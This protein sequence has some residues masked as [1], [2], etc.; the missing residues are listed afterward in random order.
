MEWEER[1]MEGPR[2][3]QS[4]EFNEILDF[5][6]Y[7]LRPKA[8]WSISQEYPTALNSENM[9]N[10]RIIKAEGKIAAHAVVQYSITKT[11][12][13]LFKVGAIGSVVTDP[14]FRNQGLSKQVINECAE[15]ARQNGCD[16]AVLWTNLYDLYR[17]LGFEL[18]GTELAL[19]IEKNFEPPQNNLRFMDTLRVAPEAL[20]RLYAE[21]TMGAIRVAD[22]F[23]RYLNIPNTHLYTAWDENN[24]LKAYAVEG[25]GADLIG[26]IHEWGGGVSSLLPLLAHI[27]KVKSSSIT[28]ICSQTAENLCRQL[29]AYGALCNRGF[30]G[31]FRILNTKN[32][33]FKLRRYARQLG[34][35]DWIFEFK[36]GAFYLGTSNKLFR[37][38]S[39]QDI[40]K[41][42]FGPLKASELE[43]FDKSTA[44]MIEEVLPLPFWIW[45]WDSV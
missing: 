15:A 40:I 10:I 38:E 33:S 35:D 7:N 12:A 8:T 43:G 9:N 36:E 37:T 1:I 13:G 28:L 20:L 26:Y 22:D 16:F 3:P 39:E 25:K 23:R 4:T 14:E 32:M 6:N 30:L 17:K 24:T 5:L 29:Q 11:V 45:G 21:H 34:H 19:I 18:G 44:E 42:L 2:P 31:M 41:L 27:R